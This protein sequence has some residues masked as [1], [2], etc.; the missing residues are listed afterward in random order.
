M[1]DLEMEILHGAS[2]AR[3]VEDSGA[4]LLVSDRDGTIRYLSAGWKRVLGWSA[5][6]MLGR[7]GHEFMHPDDV[8]ATVRVAKGLKQRGTAQ[9][10]TNRYRTMAGGWRDLEW[11][12]VVDARDGRIVASARDVTEEGAR[13][14]RMEQLGEVAHLT[15]NPVVL[16]DR[17]GRIEWV[18]EAFERLAEWRLDEVLGFT[19]GSVLQFDRTDPETVAQISR[20]LSACEPIEVEI[21]NRSRSH[22]EYWLKMEI[23]PRFDA[24]GA[25]TGFIAVE[26]DITELVAARVAAAAAET[27]AQEERARLVSAVDGLN[28]GFV[29][30]DN[31][32]R[33][34]LANRRYRE[35]YATSAP[36]MVVGAR[37]EDILRFGLERGQFAEAIGRED[38]WLRERL[39]NRRSKTPILQ[40]LA[41]GTVL[42][43]VERP[44]SEGGWVGL[45]VDVTELLDARDRAEAANRART[46]FLANMSHEIRTPLNGVLGMADLL[47]DTPLDDNQR[48]M[49]GTIR[50]SGW[51]LLA[52]LNDIVDLAR[53]EAGKL[54]LLPR[55]FDPRKLTTH[56]ATLHGATT[57]AKGISFVHL[58]DRG[59]PNLRLGDETRITQILHNLIGNAIKFTEAGSVR[60]EVKSDD[61]GKLVFR[62]SDT[63]IG[64]SAEQLARV[65]KPFEQAEAGTARRYGGAGLGLTIVQK[66]VEMMR[67]ELRIDS[68]LGRGT[69]V[70]VRLPVPIANAPKAPANAC[71]AETAGLAAKKELLRGQRLLVADDIATNRLVLAAMLKKLGIAARLAEDGAHA[72]R[73]WREQPFDLVMLDI[74]MPV[75]D[76][77]EA[78]R[79][80]RGEV[81][82]CG[83]GPL[84]A[85]AV[86]A[87][88]MQEQIEEYRR[89][90]FVETLPK[91]VCFEQLVD[92]LSRA[93]CP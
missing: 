22:R 25:H 91:P 13:L 53:V 66:L 78:L 27:R 65:Q 92:V 68:M 51:S 50:S 54:G 7:R 77:L 84:I 24:A 12:A 37:F 26:T 61:P 89:C 83:R 17:N 90:G 35:I 75:M 3:L 63:G 74:A 71:A 85:V 56:L 18:N 76:G 8:A 88:V 5:P 44:T 55:P 49:L 70:E 30:F 40:R 11:C 31:D 38:A 93:L 45:R 64:M 9:R 4:L 32:D 48:Q 10:F 42:Q 28:D 43:I 20:A 67:G 82:S 81:A 14:R 80:M 39:A 16:C 72:C 57:R 29:Y 36:S 58:K 2:V 52:M 62:I 33:L 59:P 19:P 60:L 46:E 79:I 23:Q 41:D 1:V 47:A 69:D 6:E 86:T 15:T 73:I 87:N 21:L 34:V